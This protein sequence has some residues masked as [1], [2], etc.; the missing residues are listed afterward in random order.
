MGEA[1]A[2]LEGHRIQEE[3][4]PVG[5]VLHAHALVAGSHKAAAKPGQQVGLRCFAGVFGPAGIPPA[6]VRVL[7]DAFRSAMNDPEHLAELAIFDQEV[8]YLGPEDY[9]R[10]LRAGY[11]TERLVVQRLGLAGVGE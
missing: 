10:A 8:A 5:T 4:L 1:G 6:V 7:H 9:G 3:Y 11:E 2:R